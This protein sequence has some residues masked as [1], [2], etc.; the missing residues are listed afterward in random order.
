MQHEDWGAFERYAESRRTETGLPHR[1][2]LFTRYGKNAYSDH[3][4]DGSEILVFGRETSGLPD[5]IV[6]EYK[7]KSP[8]QLLRIPVTDRCRS[9][10]LG[11]T[12]TLMV[13]ESLR[14]RGFP[15]QTISWD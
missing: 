7:E 4:Y 2:L 5:E 3:K 14:Q 6:N 9:L 1:I 15:G 12:V 10:N 11:N 13:Y 8:G